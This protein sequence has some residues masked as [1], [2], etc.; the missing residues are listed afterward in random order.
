MLSF[1]PASAFALA[2]ALT[3][4]AT[5][6]AGNTSEFTAR[7]VIPTDIEAPT[8]LLTETALHAAWPNP[9]NDHAELA[10]DLAAAGRVLLLVYDLLG[11]EVAVLVDGAQPAGHHE[12]MLDT[13]RLA[14]G[15]YVARLMVGGQ[16]L[17]RRLTVLR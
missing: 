1:T 16:A 9:A 4:T 10:Y 15:V 11:R 14:S 17:T 5:D 2:D 6:A 7:S 3:A 13:E 8:V 12:A